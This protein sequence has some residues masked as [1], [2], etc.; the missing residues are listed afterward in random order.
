METKVTL[1][2]LWDGETNEIAMMK[3]AASGGEGDGSTKPGLVWLG[4]YRSDMD[5]TK[6]LAMVE[7]AADLGCASLRFD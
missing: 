6:A 5:G 4:G 7:Q 1:N 2:H 3:A